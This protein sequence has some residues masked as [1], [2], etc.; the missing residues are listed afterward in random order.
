MSTTPQRWGISCRTC[1]W[2]RNVPEG[3]QADWAHFGH[4][5]EAHGELE[6]HAKWETTCPVDIAADVP[7]VEPA[8]AQR[9]RDYLTGL[10]RG[11]EL[12]RARLRNAVI[13]IL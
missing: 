2:K 3:V 11:R 7:D 13:N 4:G 6:E 10:A 9:G 5:L 8:I 12:E 1:D